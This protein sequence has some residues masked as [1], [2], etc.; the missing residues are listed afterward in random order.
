MLTLSRSTMFASTS[1]ITLSFRKK[2]RSISRLVLAVT[3]MIFVLLFI[4]KWSSAK[5]TESSDGDD[6]RRTTWIKRPQV[7]D[8]DKKA[9]DVKMGNSPVKGATRRKTVETKDVQVEDIGLCGD[10]S[11]E[12]DGG[13]AAQIAVKKWRDSWKDLHPRYAY[14]MWTEQDVNRL[15]NLYYPHLISTLQALNSSAHPTSGVAVGASTS[16]KHA[17][18]ITWAL[19]LLHHFGGIY[20]ASNLECLKSVDHLV[21]S[22]MRR[23]SLEPGGAAIL[24]GTY[25]PT[26]SKDSKKMEEFDGIPA[27]FMAGVPGHPLFAT[28]L[29]AVRVIVEGFVKSKEHDFSSLDAFVA[30]NMFLHNSYHSYLNRTLEPRPPVTV[31]ESQWMYPFPKA[32]HG[33]DDLC[34]LDG[35]QFDPEACKANVLR[36]SKWPAFAFNYWSKFQRHSYKATKPRRNEGLSFLMAQA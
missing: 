34:E 4:Q 2:R 1:A 22:K 8:T 7:E 29:E 31:L 33:F 32:Y 30:S 27:M 3:A 35:A 24:V 36:D 15:V 5:V 21:E 10:L 9:F 13:T 28:A 26:M 17:K 25:D 6:S 20:A 19:I 11:K 14:R 12:E 23:S 16:G 18:S